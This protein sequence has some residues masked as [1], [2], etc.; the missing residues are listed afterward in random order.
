MNAQMAPGFGRRAPVGVSLTTSAVTS[1]P[2]P[3]KT[4]AAQ[5]QPRAQTDEIADLRAVCL[6]RLEPT[7]VASMPHAKKTVPG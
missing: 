2:E 5:H 1:A 3:A 6:G 4:A 7:A